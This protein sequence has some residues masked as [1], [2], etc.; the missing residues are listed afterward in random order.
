MAGPAAYWSI[1]RIASQNRPH[2]RGV[3]RR[4]RRP[5][6]EHS[7][8]QPREIVR[9][10]WWSLPR[11]PKPLPPT[12]LCARRARATTCLA[13]TDHLTLRRSCD[14]GRGVF[15]LLFCHHSTVLFG[16][17]LT[18]D[19][20][21][22]LGPMRSGLLSWGN[23]AVQ[24]SAERLLRARRHEC[25]RLDVERDGEPLQMIDG[26]VVARMLDTERCDAEV[27]M[28]CASSSCERLSSSLLI[29]MFKPRTSLRAR[30]SDRR[31][32]MGHECPK[33]NA[34]VTLEG[35]RY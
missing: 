4:S 7:R 30:A 6:R 31:L 18:L 28:R 33:A 14:A 15:I 27:P 20:Q 19:E 16:N 35:K 2:R 5:T 11:S 17:S 24:A 3:H 8:R 13:V 10:N 26:G 25:A 1:P 34:K 21:L 22:P 32:A 23:G 9:V 12:I 29:L